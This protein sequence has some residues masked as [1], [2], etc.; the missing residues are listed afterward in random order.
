MDDNIKVRP[1]EGGVHVATDVVDGVHYPIYK[2][3]VGDGGDA[4]L[5]SQETPVP[6]SSAYS[7]EI[8]N[9]IL[10]EL[11]KLNFHMSLLTDVNISD[12]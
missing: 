8:L 1:S 6:V 7:D 2:T 12:N 9:N 5:V 11:K 10:A 3:A 4:V